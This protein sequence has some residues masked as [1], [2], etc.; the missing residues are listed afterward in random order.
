MI[1]FNG[2]ST[3]KALKRILRLQFFFSNF[4]RII[5]I[6][7]AYFVSIFFGTFIRIL[8]MIM[9]MVFFDRSPEGM[10]PEKMVLDL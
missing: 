9:W 1:Y 3:Y 7:D 10:N 8:L 4:I 2:T 6:F 5:I